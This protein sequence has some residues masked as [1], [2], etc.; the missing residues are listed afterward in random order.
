MGSLRNDGFGIVGVGGIEFTLARL[1]FTW[2]YLP[3]FIP[4]ELSFRM[5]S[6][7]SIRYV[8]QKR[9]KFSWEKKNKKIISFPNLKK[10]QKK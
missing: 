6:A 7:M 5:Q 3:V 9:D 8:V 2:D 10:S 4:S 1:N